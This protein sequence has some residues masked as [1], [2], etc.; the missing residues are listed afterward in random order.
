MALGNGTSP[1]LGA[2]GRSATLI[3]VD[4]GDVFDFP[5]AKKSAAAATLMLPEIKLPG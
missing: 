3:A 1:A 4:A 2:E 5:S